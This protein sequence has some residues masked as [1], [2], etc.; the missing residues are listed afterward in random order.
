MPKKMIPGP[1]LSEHGIFDDGS[2]RE[3][4]HT[5]RK[6]VAKKRNPQDATLRNINALKKRVTALEKEF[7]ALQ[8]ALLERDKDPTEQPPP[9]PNTPQ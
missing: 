7:R 5:R 2:V 1:V 4:T 8:D 9:S 6:T 3:F